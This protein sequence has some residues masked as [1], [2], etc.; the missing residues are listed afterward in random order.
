MKIDII[1]RVKYPELFNK[2]KQ[3][4]KDTALGE[5]GFSTM[6]DDGQPRLA[7]S[8]NLLGSLSTADILLFV[9]DDIVFLSNGWDMKIKDAIKLGF[10][11]V[12]VVGTQK[13][14]GGLIFDSGRKYG[15]GKVVGTW[16]G[17]R[18]IKLME[19]RTEIEPVKVIDGMFMAITRPHFLEQLFD[20]RFDGL[21]YYDVDMGLRSNCAVVDILVAHEKPD[22]LA[23]QYPPGMTPREYYMPI[24]NQKHGFKSDPPLGDQSCENVVYDDYIAGR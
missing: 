14:D 7:M 11:M 10:N 3:S 15:A 5:I 13:Y 22:H 24:F 23:G 19:N 1:C 20:D 8:Y 18:R 17:K 9:H 12:G 2:M 4:A 6:L 16:E 21:F